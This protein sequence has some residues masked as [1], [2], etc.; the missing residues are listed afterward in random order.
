[1]HGIWTGVKAHRQWAVK[2]R[3][4][5]L[6]CA[7]SET[8]SIKAIPV[9]L[10][11]VTTLKINKSKSMPFLCTRSYNFIGSL[12]SFQNLRFQ[13]NKCRDIYWST[14]L[15]GSS[16]GAITMQIYAKIN[17]NLKQ[18]HCVGKMCIELSAN[19]YG[20]YLRP[21]TLYN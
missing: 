1:M 8:C 16:N 11:L 14:I 7:H 6:I 3:L 15:S 21:D 20:F 5:R 19:R 10:F 2:L 17:F 18:N 4:V 13:F 12:I 9:L